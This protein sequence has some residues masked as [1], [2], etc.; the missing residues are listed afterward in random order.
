MWKERQKENRRQK[1]R[2][3]LFRL[4]I[5]VWVGLKTELNSL[6]NMVPT[7]EPRG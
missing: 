1:E 3:V 5:G 7:A 2:N 4:R 6:S